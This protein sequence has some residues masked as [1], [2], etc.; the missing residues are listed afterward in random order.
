VDEREA[1]EREANE[2]RFFPAEIS[3]KRTKSP[4]GRDAYA[5]SHLQSRW[6]GWKARAAL[7]AKSAEEVRRETLETAAQACEK[8]CSSGEN[9]DEWTITRDVA[10]H[11]CAK[12][13]RSLSQAQPTDKEQG[14]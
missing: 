3:F 11:A 2:A 4:S 12:A 10:F 7:P 14:S 6:E 9:S 5:N 13:I 1:F 8:L